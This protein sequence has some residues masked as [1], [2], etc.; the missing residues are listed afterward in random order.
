MATYNTLLFATDFSEGAEKAVEHARTLAT[1]T[2]ARLHLLH[3][4]TE[5]SDQRRKRIPADVID[6]FIHEVTE[7]ANTDME[8]FC[9][10]HFADAESQGIQ[11]THAVMFGSGYTDIIE[12]SKQL[13]ADMIILG[14]HGKTGIEKILV[15]STAERVVRHSPIPVLTVRS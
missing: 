11:L 13:G 10:R 12:A 3:V 14:T 1:L 7:V 15:G 8:A 2:G 9:Q 6:T 4:I 5:L